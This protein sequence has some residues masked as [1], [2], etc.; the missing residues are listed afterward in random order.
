M[1]IVFAACGLAVLIGLHANRATAAKITFDPNGVLE[2]D[3]KK[4]FV[5]SFAL[6]PPAG[7]KTPEAKDGLAELKDAGANFARIAPQKWPTEEKQG[8]DAAMQRIS[9]W[10]D[11]AAAAHMFCW[12]TLG[13]LPAIKPG[14]TEKEQRLRKIIARFKNHP[15]LGGWK[16]ADEPAWGKVPVDSVMRAYKIFK[17]MDPDHPVIVIH[18]PTKASLPLKPYMAACDVTGVDIYPIAYPPGMH[19]DFGNREIS[20]V[21]DCTKWVARAA[22]RKPLWMTLQ[23]AWGGTASE[24]KTLKFPTFP[25]E[26]YMAYAAI[27]NGARGIN[28]QGG[29][30]PLSLNERDAKLGWNWTFWKKV[31]RP[32]V[33]EL[34]ENSPLNPALIAPNAKLPI[35]LEGSDDVEFCVR[36]VKDELFLLAAKREGVTGK[37]KFSGLPAVD[38][39]GAV[40]FEEPRKIEVKE[41]ALEDWFGPN[42]VHVYRLRRANRPSP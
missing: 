25:E 8:S 9:A 40:M 41:G 26:R 28:Y 19:S 35:K 17:E 13:E 1:R 34:G 20:V 38:K 4:T 14:Q 27:I 7:G 32:L 16:G 30:L 10:L 2:I 5:I 31:M 6:P 21:A 39:V 23:I 22:D 24:G 11:A 37:I 12:I 33:E 15:A 18:A 29:A 36:Q 42:E 3:G